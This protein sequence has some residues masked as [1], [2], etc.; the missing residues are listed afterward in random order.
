MSSLYNSFKTDKAKENSGIAISYAPNPDGTVPTFW[1]GRL[2]ETNK[3]YQKVS[4]ELY[5]PYRKSKAAM[6]SLT[7]EVA[8]DLLK[9]GFVK[10]CL[11]KWENV[12]DMDGNVLEFSEENAY[13]L[14]DDLPDL[15]DNLM[16]QASDISMFQ[17]ERLEE[18]VKN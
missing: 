12:Q 13:K 1:V 5:K 18:E 10:G 15:L 4:K 2:S 16:E 6:K 9:K 8:Q 17:E 3:R 14:F 7:D 11:R